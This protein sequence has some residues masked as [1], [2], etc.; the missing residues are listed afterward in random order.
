MTPFPASAAWPACLSA[1]KLDRFAAGELAPE[2]SEEIRAHL[3][4]CA[5][6]TAAAESLRPPA[7]ALPPLRAVAPAPRP[8]ARPRGLLVLAAGLAAAAAV[9]L[10][11]HT[12]A[13]RERTKGPGFAVAMYVLHGDAVR[14]AGPGEVVA[15]GDA[16]R[17]AITTPVA[18]YAAVLSLDPA[19][20]ASIYFPRGPRAAPVG[21]GADVA[22]PLATRLDA[23]VG[24]EHVV[25]LL[26]ERAVDLEPIR[27]AL[28]TGAGDAIPG[29]CQVARWR[30]AKR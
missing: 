4:G 22:L 21:A 28:E 8:R 3:A 6:C 25:A 16:V 24:E 12:G 9:V 13:P 2:Q 20:R 10:V 7:A 17:F 5:R 30:F 29:G 26:C 23:T 27:A 1:L 11:V 14:Q 18:G 19:G 15:P